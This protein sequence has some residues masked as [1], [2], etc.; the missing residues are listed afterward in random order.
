M[1]K[2]I[3]CKKREL[4]CMGDSADSQ[5]WERGRKVEREL[6]ELLKCE[7]IFWKKRSKVSWLKDG[8]RNTK[9]FH[10]KASS[11]R[12]VTIFVVC[13]MWLGLG[14]IMRRTWLVSLVTIFQV[15]LLALIHLRLG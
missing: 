14:K 1:Q 7:E 6:D 10:V 15:F 4:A 3:M 11:R 9:Y 8:D 13:L 5:M 12:H 2:D